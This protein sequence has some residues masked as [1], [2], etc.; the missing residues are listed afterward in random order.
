MATVTRHPAPTSP[1]W[2]RISAALAA[3]ALATGVVAAATPA[4]PAFRGPQGDGVAPA[5]HPPVAF[6]PHSNVVWS[7][8]AP[9]GHSSP[10]VWDRRLFLTADDHGR[11]VTLCLDRRDGHTLWERSAPAGRPEPVHRTGSPAA[12]TPATDGHVVVSLFG[13]YGLV[14]HD[15][16]GHER[17][18]TPLP[19]PAMYD[20]LGSGTSPVIA[21]GLVLLV[22]DHEAGSEL[23]ALR[24]KDG[25]VAWRA[26]RGP[27][28]TSWSTPVVWRH[29][30]DSEV[31]VAG[32]VRLVAHELRTGRPTWWA[33]G[34]PGF[35]ASSPV[36]A[37]GAVF[38]SGWVPPSVTPK[39]PPFEDLLA[40][41]ANADATSVPAVSG[42]QD[43]DGL[44]AG[45]DAD[46]DGR[47][48]RAE[49]EAVVAFW[50]GRSDAT[51][52]VA[53]GGRGD[54]GATRVAWRQSRGL[55]HV[56]SPLVYRGRVYTVQNGG[57]VTCLDA[58]TGEVVY[59][60][61]RLGPGGDYYASPVAAD[62]RIYIASLDGTVSV[63]AAGD[64]PEVVARNAFDEPIA[65]SPALVGNTLYLRTRGHLHAFAARR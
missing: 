47:I 34:L 4:W 62:G 48:S 44:V 64:R 58:A 24:L 7:V 28:R 1:A 9:A 32:S 26:P 2:P 49:W 10:I 5:A 18:K 37:D 29:G 40:S 8:P 12:P 17:W 33:D 38:F 59:E 22:R 16:A 27:F 43:F 50:K 46:H 51:L 61:F 39:T 54:V 57:M 30:K 52:R 41:R 65:A 53:P 15:L 63:L 60:K 13:S 25:G 3:A 11:L 45:F 14:C 23:L 19:T 35:P 55:P 56:V 31:V 20:R 6:G 42:D 21:D 36:V